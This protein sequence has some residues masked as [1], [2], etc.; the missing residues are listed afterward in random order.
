LPNSTTKLDNDQLSTMGRCEWVL[1]NGLGG[2]AMGTANGVPDRRYHGWLVGAMQPP[3]GRVMGL[4]S[5]LEWLA[6]QEDD[7]GLG[8][9]RGRRIEL[10]SF[11]FR[12]MGGGGVIHPKGMHRLEQF[13]QGTGWARWA[14][15]L[16]D[17]VTVTRELTL[18]R[19]SN[20]ALVRYRVTGLRGKA[21]LEV[22]PLV[23]LRDY[24]S[25]W[26]ERAGYS[27]TGGDGWCE[28]AGPEAIAGAGP[29]RLWVTMAR[30]GKAKATFVGDAEWWRNFEYTRELERGMDGVEDVYSPGVFMV[31]CDH[32]D[33][34]DSQVVLAA[35]LDGPVPEG[36]LFDEVLAGHKGRV[37]VEALP[38]GCAAAGLVGRVR[39]LS[40]IVEGADQ[41]VVR[42]VS[43]TQHKGRTADAGARES[44]KPTP[45]PPSGRGFQATIV[46]GYPWFSDWG[47]DTFISMRGLLLCTGRF[48]EALAVLRAFA[49]MQKNGLIP[50]CFDNA[51]HAEYNT[52]DASLWY[53]HAACEYL[54][55]S[56]DRAGFES[57]CGACLAVIEA[58]RGGTEFDIRMD[59]DGLIAAGSEGTQLTWMDARRDGVVFTPRHG[60]AVEINALWYSGLME[61]ADALKGADKAKAA[62]LRGL[63]ERCSSSFGQFWNHDARCLFDV[64]MPVDG[65]WRPDGRVRPNQVFAVSQPYSVLYPDQKHA[66]LAVVKERLLTPMGLRTLDPADPGYRP[67][68]EGPIRERDA[69]YHNGTVWPW[70]IGAYCEGVLRAGAFSAEARDE[71]RGVIQP[72]VREFC[73]RTTQ[74]GPLRQ[75]AE[76]YDADEKPGHRRAEGCI[77]QAWSVAEVLRV[78][79]LVEGTERGTN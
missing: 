23:G 32:R 57:V 8:G 13:E 19:G 11:R 28:A 55:V 34:P 46:A 67:R 73:E 17:G 27:G 75:L 24:H 71:V 42:R 74:V 31:E 41:F 70:L 2:F 30:D 44:R 61:L 77:A 69:A 66:V 47:R 56:G 39:E 48:E 18:V 76:V 63:A 68:F 72:L 43:D 51:G 6:V 1:T 16:E 36:L 62:E 53:V 40:I 21:W 35:S 22:R 45:T 15:M 29:S 38:A 12:G 10:S 37:S 58:Y 59:E 26:R 7:A 20:T 52:V 9:P 50:N 25:L 54:R 3:V 79:C 33:Q 78:L 4:H 64:L 14:Y 60:K 49:A 65:G 5:C